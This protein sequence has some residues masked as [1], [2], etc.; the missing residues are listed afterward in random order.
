MASSKKTMICEVAGLRARSWARVRMSSLYYLMSQFIHQQ[1]QSQFDHSTCAVQ[2]K[3][4][5][6]NETYEAQATWWAFQ[7]FCSVH[8]F[9]LNSCWL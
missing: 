4:Q 5:K 1:S 6:F 7:T 2:G 9:G 3:L 8:S